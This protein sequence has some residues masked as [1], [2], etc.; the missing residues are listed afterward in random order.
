MDHYPHELLEVIP[1]PPPAL[2]IEL[3]IGTVYLNLHETHIQ[4][5]LCLRQIK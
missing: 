3:P 2:A 5:V 1:E 4:V